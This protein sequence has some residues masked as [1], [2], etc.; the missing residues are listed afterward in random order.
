MQIPNKYSE[1]TIETIIATK[2]QLN[3]QS[4]YS[5]FCYLY[6]CNFGKTSI[7]GS[8]LAIYLNCITLKSFCAK[9]AMIPFATAFCLAHVLF[10]PLDLC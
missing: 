9:P 8:N 2:F 5:L 6:D 7:F 1:I 4:K 3:L 10:I